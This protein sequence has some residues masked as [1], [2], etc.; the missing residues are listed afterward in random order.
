[1]RVNKAQVIDRFRTSELDWCDYKIKKNKKVEMNAWI[2][3]G[4][5]TNL[6]AA[7]IR[8]RG[9]TDPIDDLDDNSSKMEKSPNVEKR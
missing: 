2:K 9:F 6:E 7:H 8:P 4:E 3:S 1:M 5:S